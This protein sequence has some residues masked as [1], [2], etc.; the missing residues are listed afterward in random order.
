MKRGAELQ[1][2]SSAAASHRFPLTRS[3]IFKV[4]VTNYLFAC[5][6]FYDYTGKNLSPS[7]AQSQWQMP[8]QLYSMYQ[9]FCFKKAEPGKAFGGL[10]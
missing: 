7:L 3:N 4:L 5:Q 2:Q 10:V 9:H 1:Q 8:S 6:C